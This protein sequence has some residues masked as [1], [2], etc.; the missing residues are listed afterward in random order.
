[1]ALLIKS[2]NVN[3]ADNFSG[4]VG[5][6]DNVTFEMATLQNNHIKL[7]NLEAFLIDFSN[8]SK[9]EFLVQPSTFG[10]AINSNKTFIELAISH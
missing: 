7:G 10:L 8:V 4:S 9:Y 2:I 1:M 6:L 3:L 5:M